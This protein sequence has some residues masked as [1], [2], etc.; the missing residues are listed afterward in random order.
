MSEGQ[1]SGW[2]SMRTVA[3]MLSAADSIGNIS[4]YVTKYENKPAELRCRCFDIPGM[5]KAEIE[6]LSQELNEAITPVL[7]K[8]QGALQSKAANQLRRFL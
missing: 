1:Q 4:F 6:S 3:D 2:A 7:Q 8:V 5:S